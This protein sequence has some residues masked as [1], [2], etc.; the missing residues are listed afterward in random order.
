M[1]KS[2]ADLTGTTVAVNTGKIQSAG[3]REPTEYMSVSVDA[4]VSPPDRSPAV[5]EPVGVPVG[6]LI[7]PGAWI[8][9]GH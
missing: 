6:G 1:K 8:L 9:S 2:G 4:P 7:S 3:C 5:T